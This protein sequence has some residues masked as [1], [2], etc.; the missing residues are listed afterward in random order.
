MNQP[1]ETVNRLEE[2]ED[3]KR[4]YLHTDDGTPITLDDGTPVYVDP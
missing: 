2:N 3:D 4:I 1:E